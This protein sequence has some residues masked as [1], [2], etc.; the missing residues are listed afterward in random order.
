MR[1]GPNRSAARSDRTRRRSHECGRESCA[2]L[3][4]ARS[5]DSSTST[6]APSAAR[7]PLRRRS[8][9]RATSPPASPGLARD[10]SRSSSACIN[11]GISSTPPT[12]ARSALPAAISAAPRPTAV[13]MP[14]SRC[15]I[16]RLGPCA[17]LAMAICA[18]A[19]FAT[20]S[21]NVN[22]ETAS[23]P[24]SMAVLS[25]RS[26]KSVAP[27]AL[28]MTTDVVPSS[29]SNNPASAKA[30]RAAATANFDGMLIRRPMAGE[31]HSERLTPPLSTAR[32]ADPGR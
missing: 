4:R 8:N 19:A 20:L 32:R 5:S 30:M 2:P 6:T 22:G 26:V 25:S 7:K 16:V 10:S 14:A 3:D 29:A 15:T 23:G 28:D 27:R 12:S 1:P 21:V 13:R 24:S 17:R 11:G 9:G 18:A 31:T